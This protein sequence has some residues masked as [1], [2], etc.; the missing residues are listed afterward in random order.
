MTF[1][2]LPLT[3][4]FCVRW[5]KKKYTHPTPI[6]EQA[7]PVIL[8]GRDMIGC[9]NRHRQDRSIQYP[10]AA[11]FKYDCTRKGRRP[12]RGLVVT[13]T[14][15]LAMQIKESLDAYGRHCSL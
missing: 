8:E 5:K 9:A 10:H 13:P 2:Q 14:R 12:I 7:I 15:E 6:Q 11:A 4:P 3:A 1:D